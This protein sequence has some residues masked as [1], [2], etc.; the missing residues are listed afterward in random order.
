LNKPTYPALLGLQGARE[1]AGNMHRKAIAA[2]D[3]LDSNF[4]ELRM[5]SAY[6][7]DRTF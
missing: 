2:L 4:D 5:L 1:H 3:G 6:I 7:V